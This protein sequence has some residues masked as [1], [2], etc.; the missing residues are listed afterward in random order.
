M[1]AKD[2]YYCSVAVRL[3]STIMFS[4]FITFAIAESSDEAIQTARAYTEK[5]LPGWNIG[6]AVV[7]PIDRGLLER[8]AVEVLG[9]RKPET[10]H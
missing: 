4:N 1:S 10:V 8:A 3:D 7:V 6:N 2:L 9:W 5:A